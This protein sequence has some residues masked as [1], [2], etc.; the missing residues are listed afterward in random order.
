M[1]RAL[2]ERE[3]SRP[4]L[5]QPGGVALASGAASRPVHALR[6]V[7]LGDRFRDLQRKAF[8][9]GRRPPRDSE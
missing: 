2:V 5:Q 1:A 7:W 8:R 3:K 6:Q 4:G 9:F